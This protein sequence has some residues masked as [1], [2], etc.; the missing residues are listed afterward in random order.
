MLAV[1]GMASCGKKDPNSP[2][3]EYMPDMYRSPSYETNGANE[4]YADSMANRKPALGSIARGFLPYPYPATD[5]GYANAGRNLKNPIPY[6][7][8]VLKDGQELYGKYCTQCHGANGQ[9]DG[10]VAAK[11]PGPPPPYDGGT[12]KDLPEGKIFHSITYGKGLMGSHA[13]Q[14]T[15]QERWKLV[16]FIQKLQGRTLGAAKAETATDSTAHKDVVAEVKH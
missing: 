7:E 5:S 16:Y 9:G 10:K 12:L 6:S 3:V 13:G 4:L 1:F 14:L 11:L 8:Q 15:Q 2:G